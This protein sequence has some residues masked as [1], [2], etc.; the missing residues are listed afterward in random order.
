[1]DPAHK[2][3]L[4]VMKE[5]KA[6]TRK[7]TL[8]LTVTTTIPPLTMTRQVDAVSF[9][10][11]AAQRPFINNNNP[12]NIKPIPAPPQIPTSEQRHY[13][14]LQE[15]ELMRLLSPLPSLSGI[16]PPCKRE[17]LYMKE[18]KKLSTKVN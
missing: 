18:K 3:A 8:P 6:G 13:P 15:E 4:E 11:R 9:R 7:M 10:P 1:V 5:T 14:L 12:N 16:T 17:D 2:A